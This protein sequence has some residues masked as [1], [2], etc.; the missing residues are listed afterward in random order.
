MRT[1]LSG[2]G[3]GEERQSSGAITRGTVAA[4]LSSFGRVVVDRRNRALRE[5]VSFLAVELYD[6][7][8]PANVAD[9]HLVMQW[10]LSGNDN[11]LAVLSPTYRVAP[12]KMLFVRTW[13]GH[14]WRRR[15]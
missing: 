15:R 1:V 2:D 9:D 14:A 10:I 7:L 8:V 4:F 13:R 3:Q 11:I 6:A 12:G 5:S